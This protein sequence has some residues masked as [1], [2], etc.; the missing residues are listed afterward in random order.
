[1]SMNSSAMTLLAIACTVFS[2]L[3]GRV[4][5]VIPQSTS[6]VVTVN[7]NSEDAN[8]GNLICNAIGGGCSLRAAL[9]EANLDGVPSTI[10]F[11]TGFQDSNKIIDCD[12]PLTESLTTI[13][14]SSAWD[15][16]NVRPG[17]RVFSS[18]INPATADKCNT[19]LIT[20]AGNVAIFG[21]EIWSTQGRGI[22]AAN[23]DRLTI[24]GFGSHQ[25]NVF[26]FNNN[27]D[28]DLIASPNAIVQNNFFGATN[29]YDPIGGGLIGIHLRSNS[30]T[31]TKNV[32]FLRINE[33]IRIS[34]DHNWI[35]DNEIGSNSNNAALCKNGVGI[36]IFGSNNTIGPANLIVSNAGNG[37]VLESPT[38]NTVIKSNTIGYSKEYGN[39]G[40]GIFI[41]AHAEGLQ[42]LA[43]SIIGN[44]GNGITVRSSNDVTIA[45]NSIYDNT[46]DGV[47]V[48]WTRADVAGQPTIGVPEK[49]P[50]LIFGNGGNGIHLWDVDN[51]LVQGNRIGLGGGEG[52]CLGSCMNSGF[53][54]LL[55]EGST[56]N[57]IGG[58]Y[59]NQANWIGNSAQDGVRIQ[60]SSTQSNVLLGNVIGAPVHRHKITGNG[61]HGVGIYDGAHDNWI[62]GIFGGNTILASGWSGVA[63]VNAP[64]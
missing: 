17:V 38:S 7:T 55:E 20:N 29:G 58:V 43:N 47:Q 22:A 31:V 14:A 8:P 28:V 25:S 11:A 34:G 46:G 5:P 2:P 24:G 33:A 53:G 45:E 1:M 39:A 16:V 63:V 30:G 6:Y 13:D 15:T 27:A 50:N 61:W 40:D 19:F 44:A 42:I 35:Y 10:T 41:W 60:G 21:L 62:G 18:G 64:Q 37:I 36:D 9:T 23:A 59:D 49:A 51:A 26:A 54:I 3:S 48:R 12:L 52:A 56:L 57:T 32:F 4:S